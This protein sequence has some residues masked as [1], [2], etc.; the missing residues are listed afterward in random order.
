MNA[1]VGEKY[2]A[3]L[4]QLFEKQGQREGGGVVYINYLQELARLLMRAVS[5]V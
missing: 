1:A 4:V 5:S 3:E 2:T